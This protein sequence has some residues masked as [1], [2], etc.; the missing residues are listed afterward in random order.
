MVEAHLQRI[1]EMNPRLGALSAVRHAE[2]LREADALQ[3]RDD[4]AALPLAGVPVV[5]KEN[6][7]VAGLPT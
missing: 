3:H 1:A 6:V 7:D 4:L 2:A 5:V